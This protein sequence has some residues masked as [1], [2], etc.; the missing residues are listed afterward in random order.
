MKDWRGEEIHKGSRV[1]Y[2]VV[3]STTVDMTEGIVMEV[4][5]PQ[6][7]IMR[8]RDWYDNFLPTS[9]PRKVK[10]F[11]SRVTVVGEP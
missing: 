11:A 1:V 3:H 5:I 9:T 6:L 2:P 8:L 4:A 7:T 10:V